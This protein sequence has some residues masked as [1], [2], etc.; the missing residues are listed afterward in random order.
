[1]PKEGEIWSKIQPRV[2]DT[3]GNESSHIE[4][5]SGLDIKTYAGDIQLS[6]I[7]LNAFFKV[8]WV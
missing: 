7:Y 3:W 4:N 6:L 5:F 8:I 1:M 2:Y